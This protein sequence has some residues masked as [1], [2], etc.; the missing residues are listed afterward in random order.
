[1]VSIGDT[2]QG[3]YR[4]LRLIGEGAMGAVY[5]GEHLL[6]HRRVAIKVL[7]AY[8]RT[9]EAAARFEREAQA[10][11]QIESDHI[12]EVL[13]L[14]RLDDDGDHFI[15]ME[16]LSG[17]TLGARFQRLGRHKPEQLVP[18][19]RQVLVGL[20]AAH[21]AG[22]VHRDIKPE[23]LF[24]LPHKAGQRDFVKILDFGVSK[25]R[26]KD[27]KSAHALTGAGSMMGTPCY[28]SPEQARGQGDAGVLTDLYAVGVVLYEGLTGDVPFDGNNLNELL[29]KIGEG[30]FVPPRQK[31]PELDSRLDALV[32]KALAYV[33]EQRF[34]SAD[35]FIDALDAWGKASSEAGRVSAP[36]P[37]RGYGGDAGV[38]STSPME[39]SITLPRLGPGA[40]RRGGWAI[41]LGLV[42]GGSV[43]LFYR[44]RAPAGDAAPSAG[45]ASGAR[46][47]APSVAGPDLAPRDVAAGK[48]QTAPSAAP[49]ASARQTPASAPADEAKPASAAGKSATAAPRASRASAAR[50]RTVAPAGNGSKQPEPIKARRMAKPDTASVSAAPPAAKPAGAP[51][52][53]PDW[54][55]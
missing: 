36:A 51:K 26:D 7:H 33:P 25:F 35:E 17:E 41:L 52:V 27:D 22:I 24:V 21:A 47:P 31:A 32:R 54:G 2:L 48:P 50:V 49:V 19:L 39:H 11:G 4:I 6:I 29:F 9:A 3:R 13:D 15:V 1:M 28:M 55:Y 53:R 38:A 10:A 34:Q 12:T 43:S 44:A 18:L 40:R 46:L 30:R 42:L 14:G 8:T 37:A 20:A 23:N 45:A 16:F 5:E